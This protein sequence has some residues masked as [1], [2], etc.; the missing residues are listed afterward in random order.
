MILDDSA[1]GWYMPT[2]LFTKKEVQK[3]SFS[4]QRDTQDH[5][6]FDDAH[7]QAMAYQFDITHLGYIGNTFVEA[8]YPVIKRRNA[9]LL[10]EKG[11]GEKTRYYEIAA[12][13]HGDA[14]AVWT[15]GWNPASS[16][17]PHA[18]TSRC[19]GISIEMG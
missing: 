18:Q 8:S 11:L 5:L 3:G 7:R 2:L 1:G 10:V 19:L 14:G 6:V 17:H 16:R 9:R 4:V 12:V 13:S 15:A